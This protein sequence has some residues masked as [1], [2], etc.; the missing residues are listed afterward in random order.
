MGT[1]TRQLYRR[2]SEG[3]G[4]RVHAVRDDQ[5]ALPTPCGEWDVRAVVNHVVGENRWAVPLF[6]GGTI[7]EVGDRYDGDLLG[8]DPAVAWDDSAAAAA[9][10]VDAPGAVDRTVH[11]SFGDVPG[12]EYAMQLFADLLVHGWDL[13]R[14]I[15]ADERLDPELVDACAAW[16]ATVAGSYRAGGAVGP[17]VA[18]PPDADPQTV[19]LADFGRTAAG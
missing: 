10:S 15:G 1:D 18:T 8:G 9:A 2:A 11:L 16:F 3:F 12:H 7:E 6:A 14:A 13:S 17:R 19:L 4:E 5:W